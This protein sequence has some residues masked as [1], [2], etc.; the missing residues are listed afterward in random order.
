MARIHLSKADV[1]DVEAAFVLD[2]LRSGWVA[3]LGPD[4]DAFEQEL[5]SRL[6]VGHALALSSGTAALHLA[7]L[8][9][10]AGPGTAVLC[11]TLTFAASAN[12]IVYTGATPVFVDAAADDGNVDAQLLL[13]AT[14]VLQ[15]EGVTVAAALVVDLFGRCA[16]YPVLVEGLAARGVPLIE[17]AAESLGA[18]L[19]GRPAGSF[20]RA[21][22]LSFNGNKVMT[23]SGGG[24]L[25]SDDGP[26]VER[27]RYL[28]TQAR[29]P[30][31]WYEH[32]EVG[33]NYRLSNILAALGR[34]QLS[35]LDAMVAR[36]RLIRQRYVAA[37]GDLPGVRFLG[38]DGGQG[39]Y[40]DNCWLTT[41]ELDPERAAIGPEELLAKLSAEDIEAR[42]LWKPMHRQPVFAAAR[43]F[44]TG[45]AER[46][47]E[48]GLALPSGS[49]VSDE[50]LERVLDQL[51]GALAP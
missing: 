6:G 46:L 11:P 23:T 1:G 51:T 44:T 15:A 21:A 3:P 32:V 38:G 42:H 25:L 4:V 9:V 5:A 19:D 2:A 20:G 18:C 33:Y 26:L 13:D 45:T 17:D 28:S 22:A 40:Q 31:P 37:L 27:A 7:L 41:I 35:R 50:D 34:A 8:G 16:D 24:M 10:G 12:A 36:R 14:A 39:R 48:R 43:A 47:F 29:Q 30:V 49:S